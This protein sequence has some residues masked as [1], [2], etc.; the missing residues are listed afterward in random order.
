MVIISSTL[1]WNLRPT[2]LMLL[3]S[4]HPG[5][6]SF[7]QVLTVLRNLENTAAEKLHTLFN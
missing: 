5:E 4:L 1:R 6:V 2:L 3:S 7:R